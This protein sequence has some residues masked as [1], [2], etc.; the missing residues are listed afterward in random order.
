[1]RT[2]AEAHSSPPGARYAIV[3]ARFHSD[4]VE[5]LVAGAAAGFAQAGLSEKDYDLVWVPG[6]FELPLAAQHLAKTGR[7][8]ANI[9]LGCVIRGDTDHYDHICRAAADGILRAGLDTGLPILFG[10]LTCDTLEQAFARAGGA[11]GNKGT[12]AAL[13]AVEMAALLHNIKSAR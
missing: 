3:A 5:K 4:V 2:N 10:V 9:C 11:L 8:A 7:Y 6:S 12:D 13:A 1:L